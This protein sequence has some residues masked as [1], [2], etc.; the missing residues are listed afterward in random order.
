MLAH[1]QR[2]CSVNQSKSLDFFM[3]AVALQVKGKARSFQYMGLELLGSIWEKMK[4]LSPPTLHYARGL[5]TYI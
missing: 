3:V 5:M 2:N 4:S 1:G